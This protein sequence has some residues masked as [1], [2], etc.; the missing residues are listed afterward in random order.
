MLQLYGNPRSRAI[1]CLWMLE[2]VG[3][4]YQLVERST[5]ADDLQTAEYLRLNPNARIPTLVDGDVVLWES[6]AINLYLAQKY[7]G[8]MHCTNPEVLGLA[9]QWSFW[10]ML[11]I[12]HLLLHLLEHRALLAEFARDPSA[13]ERNELLLKKPLGVLNDALAGRD[14]LAGTSFTVADL[15]VASILVWAKMARLDLSAYPDLTRWLN[16]CL[17]RP[18][19]A[20]VRDQARRK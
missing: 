16:G 9:A 5:R 11:E 7:D 4:P 3:R 15:N 12:E 20:R 17:A 1:R 8:P 10:A 14:Y 13:I 19:Y 18:A 2:E 6:M